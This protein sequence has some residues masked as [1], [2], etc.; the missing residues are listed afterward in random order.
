MYPFLA[1]SRALVFLTQ[2]LTD[3]RDQVF[4][5]TTGFTLER[6]RINAAATVAWRGKPMLEVMRAPR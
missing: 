1:L 3:T 2:R 6:G 5:G 4:G